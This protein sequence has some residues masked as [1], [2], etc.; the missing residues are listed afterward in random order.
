MLE[1]KHTNMMHKCDKPFQLKEF[2]GWDN[3]GARRLHHPSHGSDETIIQG[4]LSFERRES[5]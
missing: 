4:G 5:L 3:V 2:E 1:E